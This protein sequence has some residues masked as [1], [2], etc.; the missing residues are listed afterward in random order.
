[1]VKRKV[2]RHVPAQQIGTDIVERMRPGHLVHHYLLAAYCYY[3]LNESPL[4]DHAF[5]L[6]CLRLHEVYDT[7]EHPHKYLVNKEHLEAGTCLLAI[8]QYPTIV[9][10]GIGVYLASIEDGS[11]IERLKANLGMT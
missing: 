9:T 2:K 10:S 7:F 3:W 4:T 6:L 5:D 1:M 11:L 8:D